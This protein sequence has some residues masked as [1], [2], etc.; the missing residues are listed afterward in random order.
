M[1][2]SRTTA[3]IAGALFL[4]SNVTFLLGAV[5]FLGSILGAQDY[6]TLVPTKS[7]QVVTGALLELINGVAY[8]AIAALMFPIFTRRFASM[9]IAYVAFRIIEFVMQAISDISA[10]SLLTLSG[11]FTSAASQSQPFYQAYGAALLADRQSASLM[12]TITFALGALLLYTMLYRSRLIPRFISVWGLLGAIMV[13]ATA[14]MDVYG[15]SLESLDALG[16]IML[17]NEL[18]LGVWLIVKGFSSSAIASLSS[19]QNNAA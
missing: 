6:L 3:R 5:V 14:L 1:T 9:A 8:L 11:Q 19:A 12:V 18:F 4:V 7:A 16:F 13:L 17:L 15:I 2:T 10:L